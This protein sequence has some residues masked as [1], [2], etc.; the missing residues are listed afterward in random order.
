VDTPRHSFACRTQ[1]EFKTTK[2]QAALLKNSS[3]GNHQLIFPAEF[4]PLVI[5]MMAQLEIKR[6]E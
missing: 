4:I 6:V 5:R 1:I 3:L 2:G